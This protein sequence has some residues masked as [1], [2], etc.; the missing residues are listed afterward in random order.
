MQGTEEGQTEK[1]KERGKEE[2]T[3]GKEK[4]ESDE[5]RKGEEL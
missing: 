3:V 2:I 4:E 1:K 5:D